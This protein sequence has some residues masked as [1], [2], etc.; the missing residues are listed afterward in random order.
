MH[1]LA[2]RIGRH[3]VVIPVINEGQRIRDQLKRLQE[4]ELGIDVVVAD[5]GSTD[6]SNGPDLLRGL[7]VRALLVKLER[8]QAL[9]PTVDRLRIRLARG[10]RGCRD[11]RREW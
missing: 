6:G 3:S 8:R 11:R 9:G 5:G 2:E 10:V 7:G 4:L 1:V